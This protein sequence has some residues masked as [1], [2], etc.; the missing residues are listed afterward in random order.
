MKDINIKKQIRTIYT[1]SVFEALT[2]AGAS[3]VALLAQRGYSLAQI[4]VLEGIFH[5][6]S[7]C[8]EIPSGVVADVL[9]RK[10]T[11]VASRCMAI[12]STVVMI[13]SDSFWSIAVAMGTS[14]LSYNLASGTREALAYDSLKSVSKEEY[15][16]RYASTEMAIY[17]VSSAVAT[18]CAGFALFLGYKGAYILDL[19]V[20]LICLF[21]ALQLK[22]VRVRDKQI[23]EG[24]DFIFANQDSRAADISLKER[25]KDCILSSAG[26][27]KNNP[28]AVWIIAVNSLVGAIATLLLFFL[29]AKLP[30]L[31]LP[32]QILGPALFFMSMGAALGAKCVA[33][34]PKQGYSRYLGISVMGIVIALL[35]WIT[36][37]PYI[38][39]V[40]G[41]V[42]AFADDFLEVQTDILLNGM[43]PSE[44]RATLISVCSF[45]FSI[46]M[47][48]M[49]PLMGVLLN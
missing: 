47:I 18:L 26:F 22:E 5:A 7:L 44:Q 11:M 23:M 39:C 21:F 49:S 12:L 31:G 6:V 17:R 46:V 42:A 2:I 29:Q 1:V 36:G 10:K 41:F 35:T 37:N 14:A 24:P 43:I 15:Y 28:K 25:F 16:D 13:F 9:G 32:T 40:G 33:H 27:L 4:G 48:V 45:A 20:E 19:I 3:W 34:F 30:K 38:V 8:G